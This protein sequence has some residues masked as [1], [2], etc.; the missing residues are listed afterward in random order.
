MKRKR[1]PPKAYPVKDRPGL[2]RAYGINA[3]TQARQAFFGR[4]REEAESEARSSYSRQVRTDTFAE[5]YFDAY[6]PTIEARSENW[7]NQ[8]AWAMDKYILREFGEWGIDEI[9]RPQLQSF[10]NRLRRKLSD[11]SAARVKIVLSGVLNL[12]VADE[13][14]TSNPCRFVKLPT[15]SKPDKIALT[16]DQLAR[17]FVA[18]KPEVQVV[19]LLSGCA[20]GLRIGEA[21]GVTRLHLT[22][23]DVLHVRQQILQAKGGARISKTLKTAQTHRDL[24]LP[25]ELAEWIRKHSQ[26]RFYLAGTA[27]NK[28]QLPNNVTEDLASACTKAKVATITPHELRHT[29]ISLMENEIEAPAAVVA[30]L[31]GKQDSRVTAGYSHTHQEQLRKWL[32]VYFQ[33]FKKAVEEACVSD[34]LEHRA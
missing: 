13:K 7:Q 4:T 8:I 27:K 21:C 2:F 12:A 25:E 3:A 19:I 22:S 15:P 34:R 29:F 10:F 24:P 32:S 14:I 11:S 26:G 33:R 5:F 17:V 18:A 6:L 20:A 1:K 23:D 31:A 9:K 28:F 30:A 16:F